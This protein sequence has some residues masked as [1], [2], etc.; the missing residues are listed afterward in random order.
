[1]IVLDEVNT[2]RFLRILDFMNYF[3]DF[4]ITEQIKRVTCFDLILVFL[5][6]MFKRNANRQNSLDYISET[7]DE[8]FFFSY[9]IA[10]FHRNPNSC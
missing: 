5:F 1:M 6:V 7:Q 2:K 9:N 3:L 8:D 4:D 10:V